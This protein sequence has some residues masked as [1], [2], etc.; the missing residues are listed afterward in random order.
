MLIPCQV[1]SY[2]QLKMPLLWSIYYILQLLPS[3]PE[4]EEESM[5]HLH[6]PW[7]KWIPYDVPHNQVRI[8]LVPIVIW[9]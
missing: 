9:G 4:A 3:G 6:A 5:I 1:V 2:Q 8:L 7:H